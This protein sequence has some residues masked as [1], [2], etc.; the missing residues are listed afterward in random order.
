M[1]DRLTMVDKLTS[2][3][4]AKLTM[5]DRCGATPT[6]ETMSWPRSP[7]TLIHQGWFWQNKDNFK[8][9][10]KT[11]IFQ[12][13]KGESCCCEFRGNLG[14]YII[15]YIV[16]LLIQCLNNIFPFFVKAYWNFNPFSNFLPPFL[17]Q[18]QRTKD[19]G[20]GELEQWNILPIGVRVIFEEMVLLKKKKPDWKE[21]HLRSLKLIRLAFC[22]EERRSDKDPAQTCNWPQDRNN[23]WKRITERKT[24]WLFCKIYIQGG[25]FYCSALKMTKCQPLKEI[26]ELFLPKND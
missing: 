7:P 12:W 24:T 26:S 25:F 16:L 15:D 13:A 10:K 22:A 2:W 20:C 19:A 21:T 1:V 23:A 5:V 17:A 4:V 14:F 18:N 9:S 8:I 3:Q 6:A 11:Q